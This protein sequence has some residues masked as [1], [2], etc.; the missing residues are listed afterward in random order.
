MRILRFRNRCVCASLC[1]IAQQLYVLAGL[2]AR[3]EFGA[4]ADALES[5]GVEEIHE[6]CVVR[7]GI[8]YL[9]AESV[10]AHALEHRD[11]EDAIVARF[12]FEFAE[13]L[14]YCG[15]FAVCIGDLDDHS[16][17]LLVGLRR[18]YGRIV[19]GSSAFFSII[20]QEVRTEPQ[21]YDGYE[22]KRDER[23]VA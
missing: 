17:Y 19:V 7:G 5:V 4:R 12:P 18:D 1:G 22:H 10:V 23:D 2:Y 16:G 3:D 6:A 20:N 14:P 8:L 9:V 15:V 13:A 11:I 21:H